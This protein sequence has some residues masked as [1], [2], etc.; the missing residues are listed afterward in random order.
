MHELRITLE[1][2]GVKGDVTK[3]CHIWAV[4]LTIFYFYF[5]F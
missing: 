1:A 4:L 3:F 2:L 5:L